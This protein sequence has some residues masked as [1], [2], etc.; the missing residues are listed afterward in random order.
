MDNTLAL[1]RKLVRE[2]IGREYF[3]TKEMRNVEVD[4]SVHGRQRGNEKMKIA[5][6]RYQLL[7]NFQ[8]LELDREATAYNVRNKSDRLEAQHNLN[9]EIA[10]LTTP[11]FSPYESKGHRPNHISEMPFGKDDI[12]AICG[13]Y[14]LM[15]DQSNTIHWLKHR[16]I[17]SPNLPLPEEQAAILLH[18]PHMDE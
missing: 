15:I 12:E 9:S 13:K 14:N 8:K 6:Q 5:N 7:S 1:L 3:M 4:P 16:P 11:R 18:E 2:T 17:E 10:L